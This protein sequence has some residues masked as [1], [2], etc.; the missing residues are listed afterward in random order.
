MYLSLSSNDPGMK[1]ETSGVMWHIALESKIKF[2]NCELSP[3]CSLGHSSL[4]DIC[5]IDAYI[6]WSSLFS[7]L[8]HARLTFSLNHTLFRCFLLS[9]GGFGHVEIR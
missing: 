4:L 3:K 1:S 2:V 5:A 8:L 7:P 6:F 9:F